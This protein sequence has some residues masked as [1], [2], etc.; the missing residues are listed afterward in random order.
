MPVSTRHPSY[1]THKPLWDF[2]R[3]V[4]AGNHA[5]KASKTE[6]LPAIFAQ[7]EPDRY[8]Q[9]LERA[10][11][12]G[13]TGRTRDAFTGMVFRKDATQQLPPKM[14]ELA[15]NIN[16]SGQS[17]GQLAKAMVSDLLEV[18]RF[19]LLVDYPP[20]PVGTD[21]QRERE[22]GAR[23]I[24]A[25]YPAESIVNWQ[26]A[27]VGNQNK[28]T[29]VV[30]AE[31]VNISPDEFVTQHETVYRVLRLRD[32]VYSQTLYDDSGA[33]LVAEYNP[34]AMGQTFD[35]IPFHIAGSVDNTPEPDL[36]T[37][38]DL[39]VVNVAHYRNT[40][41]LEESSFICGQPTFH[42][43]VGST[44]DTLFK[45][46]NPNGMQV[47]S[48]SGTLTKGGRLE[49]VQAAPNNLPLTLMQEKERQ[50]V[51]IG[52]RIVT[53]GGQAQTAEAARLEAS[54]EASTLDNLVGNA[55]EA[56][57]AA[58]ED[59]ARFVGSDPEQVQFALNKNYWE[60]NLTAQD[61]QAIITGVGRIYAPLDAIQMIRTGRISLNPERNDKTILQDAASSALD[62]LDD[63][64]ITATV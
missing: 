17:L 28:L 31:Q 42:L 20:V 62:S 58:L 1:N 11:L 38:Y 25:T 50:M 3:R 15:E 18:G 30:L 10:Y 35:H 37:L 51:A 46:L 59:M 9:Y 8:K 56:L 61:L 39:A 63:L 44:D 6:D 49:L 57:E 7:D 21:S 34:K 33:E 2:V 41:D 5:V 23:P 55:S 4:C 32:G 43:D 36:P 64:S 53:R 24:I 48:R 60:Q 27:K 12:L 22:L 45:A 52:A 14:A 26:T 40:A 13:V 29:L 47:G 54:A 16:G 19:G